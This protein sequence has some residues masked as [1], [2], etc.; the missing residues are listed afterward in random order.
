[1]VAE[2]AEAWSTAASFEA[3]SLLQANG[4]S[5]TATARTTQIA[6]LENFRIIE[7]APFSFRGEC[8]SQY[9]DER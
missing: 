5:A 7:I 2:S 3:E 1:V 8:A 9:S 6:K 4:T